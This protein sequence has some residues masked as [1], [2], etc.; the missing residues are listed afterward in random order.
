MDINL[1][2]NIRFAIEKSN[3]CKI[4]NSIYFNNAY[5]NL[6]AFELNPWTFYVTIVLDNGYIF[7]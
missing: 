3:Q 5:N 1:I 4:S 7:I 2:K 6:E